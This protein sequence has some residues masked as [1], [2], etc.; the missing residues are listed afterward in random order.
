MLASA[1]AFTACDKDDDDKDK[2]DPKMSK[3]YAYTFSGSY[4][5]DHPSNL[6]ADLKITEI[7]DN[8]A[9]VEVTLRNTISGEMYMI[10][11][12]DAADPA[13]T[14]NN[15][16]YNETP[17]AQVL[18]Q[19]ATGNGGDVTVSQTANMSYA[20]LTSSYEAFFVVHDP[21][22]DISTTDLTTYLVV[23]G[24]AREQ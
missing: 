17:N 15:T 19:M 24:F 3:T 23:G 1:F 11:A 13:T 16:P 22:Q 10:H 7:D 14:P 18:V 12:H 4:E 6:S 9:K 20:E 5:G 21:L 2:E 8:S